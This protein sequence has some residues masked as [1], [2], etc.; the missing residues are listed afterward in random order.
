VRSA[1]KGRCIRDKNLEILPPKIVI[2][3]GR[4]SFFD[5]EK[6]EREIAFISSTLTGK[7]LQNFVED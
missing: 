2:F 6:L 4:I 5:K 1:T 3:G 7:I